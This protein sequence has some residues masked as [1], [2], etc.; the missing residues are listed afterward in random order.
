[1]FITHL[2]EYFMNIHVLDRAELPPRGLSAP[3][4]P[5]LAMV[6]SSCYLP[7][8]LQPCNNITSVCYSNAF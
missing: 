6:F 7:I 8:K 5:D 2:N 1:M 3:M 4:L